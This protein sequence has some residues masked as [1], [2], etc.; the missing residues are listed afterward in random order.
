MILLFGAGGQL[1]RELN[2]QAERAG[3]PLL[4]LTRS[5]VDI[6]DGDAVAGAVGVEGA[7]MVVN[8]AAY[9]NVDGAEND[10]DTAFA[11]NAGGAANIAQASAEAGLPLVHMSTDYVF[12]GAKE[13]AYRE[14]DPVG[15]INIYGSSKLEGERVVRQA[16]PRHV[17][18]RT[19]WVYG[20]YGQNFLKRMVGL[21]EQSDELRVVDDQW[22][23]PTAT[24]DL[25]QAILRIWARRESAPWG[26]YHFAGQGVTSWHGFAERIVGAQARFSGKHPKVT[27]VTSAEYTTR[28]RRPRNSALD[29]ARFALTFGLTA[30]PWGEAVER[31][32]GELMQKAEP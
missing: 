25:A 10:P 5:E 28:A 29:S 20:V 18:L 19:S 21:A 2:E 31:V 22:G 32:V 9:T 11:V 16:N 27:A 30:A 8:A 7:G 13:G 1:G 23:C 26:T 12:N 15:P 6:R 14:D 4:A 3:V 24:A 17:I